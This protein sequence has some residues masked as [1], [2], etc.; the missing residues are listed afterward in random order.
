VFSSVLICDWCFGAI[1]ENVL[2]GDPIVRIDHQV[3][4]WFHQHATP[5]ITRVMRT[6]SFFGS[7]AWLAV[8]SVAMALFFIRRRDWLDLFLVALNMNGG[9][10]LNV[11]LKH[12]FHRQRP[13]LE[14]PLVTL[15]SYGFPSGHT[16]GA[17]LLY[18]LLALLAW[19][20][21]KNR[22]ARLACVFGGCF[23]ILLIGLSRMYLGAHY[24]SDVLGA[25]AAGMLWLTVCWTA[26]ET[27]RL[28]RDS[29]RRL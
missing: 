15:S 6:V 23:L 12:F 24:L 20:N 28:R 8:V 22:A 25:I 18:G 26:I 4:H 11:V 9:G 17:T 2:E 27:L 3:A 10:V 19:K 13:V 14:N 16:M 1:A 21:L 7:V 29:A 5:P